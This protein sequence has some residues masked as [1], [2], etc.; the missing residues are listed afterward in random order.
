MFISSLHYRVFFLILRG[1]NEGKVR[2]RSQLVRIKRIEVLRSVNST[3]LFTPRSVLD[4][5]A[6]ALHIHQKFPWYS[7]SSLGTDVSST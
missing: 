4:E 2:D 3:G 1:E 7:N 5:L 6:R